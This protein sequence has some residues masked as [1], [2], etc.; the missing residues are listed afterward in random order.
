MF[1]LFA[2]NGQI[3]DNDLPKVGYKY[4]QNFKNI[5]GIFLLF[6]DSLFLKQFINYQFFDTI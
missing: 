5:F 2:Y 6:I 1:V 3:L 4:P